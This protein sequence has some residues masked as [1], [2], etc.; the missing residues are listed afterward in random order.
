METTIRKVASPI[1]EVTLYRLT[2]AKGASVEL[3]SLGAGITE[4]SVPDANGKIEN[5]TLRY[6][7][8]ASYLADGPCAG[9]TPGRFANRICKGKLQI[10]GITYDLPINNGPNHLH[11][12]PEGF[13][14]QIWESEEVPDGVL[15]RY[16]SKDGEMGYPGNLTA[17]VKYTWNDDNELT[18]DLSA[19]SDAKTVVN[20]TNHAY[21]NLEGADGAESN[22]VLGHELKL[23]AAYFLPGDET[24]I[25][26]GEM[27]P[28]AA[29]P[30]DFTE[31]KTL[32]EDINKDFTP[33][34][35]GKG[36]DHCF[37]IDGPNGELRE[38]CVLRSPKSRRRMT[39]LT[40]QPGVQIYTGN[41]LG[42]SPAN[43]AGRSYEDYEGVAMEAQGFPDAPSHAS[44]PSPRVAPDSPY[45]RTI[46][47]RF[48]TF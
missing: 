42:G 16:H 4:V 17:E 5:V 26:S 39:V 13:Q 15:F 47:Y 38:A 18:I 34:K 36:Y 29:T 21:F 35:Y 24:L 22:S 1:G 46:V 8:P 40:D 2:N 10:D 31:F 19:T 3:S 9:K 11:G 28:V 7:D 43:V 27:A 48:D 37:C 20:L 12:G 41:Y 23:N 32:G 14:N 45:H 44:F 33:L 30:M 25:P 6:A